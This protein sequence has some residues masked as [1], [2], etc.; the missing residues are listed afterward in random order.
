MFLPLLRSTLAR[1]LLITPSSSFSSSLLH[2]T[3]FLLFTLTSRYICICFPFNRLLP[4]HY[5]RESVSTYFLH[6]FT[7]IY[8]SGNREN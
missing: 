1:L 7:L 2:I 8:L 6:C 5:E 4:V 3:I